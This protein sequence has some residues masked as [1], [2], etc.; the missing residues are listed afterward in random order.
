MSNDPHERREEFIDE[1]VRARGQLFGFVF[2][3]VLNMNDAEDLLQQT[4][5]TLWEEFE[6]FEAGTDFLNWS[7]KIAR[8]KA[9]DYFRSKKREQNCLSDE[10]LDNLAMEKS[11]TADLTDAR[12]E[13]LS[14]CLEKLSQK[15]RELI[16]DCYDR[17]SSIIHIAEQLGR[18]V[19]SVYVSLNRIR[20]ALFRCVNTVVTQ[21]DGD[22]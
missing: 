11:Q 17:K 16:E 8:N 14:L 21:E 22:V 18:S 9:I 2:S 1:L 3:I 19:N 12:S 10:V 7:C 13:A 4:S 15:D 20:R 5:L 6:D